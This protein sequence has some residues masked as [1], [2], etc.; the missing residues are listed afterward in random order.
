M[1]RLTYRAIVRSYADM[2]RKG[3]SDTDLTPRQARMCATVLATASNDGAADQPY[4]LRP[5]VLEA[6]IGRLGDAL[7]NGNARAFADAVS[8]SAGQDLGTAI[9]R[10][11]V[12]L[13]G[14]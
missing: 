11:Y 1:D 3:H 13:R 14:V 4:P 7:W 12:I 10:A 9:E 6:I 8:P 5:D 2:V